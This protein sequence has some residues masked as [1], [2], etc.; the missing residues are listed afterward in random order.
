MLSPP[1][2]GLVTEDREYFIGPRAVAAFRQGGGDPDLPGI[3]LQPGSHW[4]SVVTPE[5]MIGSG[6][7]HDN[8][9]D[10]LSVAA[11]ADAGY[12]VDMSKTTPWVWVNRTSAAAAEPVNDVVI[13]WPGR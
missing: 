7:D 9:P 8:F 6:G 12:A 5:V 2:T 13:P 1:A 10:E 3:P 11:L 4:A